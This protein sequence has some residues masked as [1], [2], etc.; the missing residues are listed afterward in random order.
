[1]I[2]VENRFAVFNALQA[3][4]PEDPHEVEALLSRTQVVTAMQCSDQVADALERFTFRRRPFHTSLIDLTLSEEELWGK[5]EKK[6]CRYQINKARKLAPEITV[7]ERLEAAFDL[8]NAFVA[9]TSFRPPMLRAEWERITACCDVFVTSHEGKPMAAHVIISDAP[10]CARALMSA[11]ADRA[12]AAERGIAGALNRHLHWHE[13]L[14]YKAEGVRC[15][16]LGGVVL[17][18][19]LPEHSI[20]QFKA[21]FGGRQV[22]HQVVHLARNPLLRGVLRL[23]STRRNRA[24]VRA[25]ARAAA[26]P[27]PSAPA[28]APAPTP[29]VEAA[30]HA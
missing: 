23:V 24:A 2:V 29:V 28:P 25:A 7:N 14:H 4:F 21:M 30:A 18:E 26:E 3:W 19:S 27:K 13:F 22:T 15:Y 12:D 9:R 5:L 17:D 10:A 16:D 20:A 8:I 11:T 1:M 6:T